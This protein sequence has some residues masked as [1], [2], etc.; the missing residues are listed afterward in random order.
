M[1]NIQKIKQYIKIVEPKKS[2]FIAHLIFFMAR[3]LLDLYLAVPSANAITNITIG[4]TKS[5]IKW[6]IVVCIV[7]C[8]QQILSYI[9]D[10]LYYKT[11][12]TCWQNIYAKMYDKISMA[13]NDSFLTTSKQKIINTAYN[14][15]SVLGEFPHH[16][17]KYISFFIQAIVT[18]FI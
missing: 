18:I 2:L 11:I 17:T 6:L 13:T 8:I 12:E 16:A 1:N 3:Y 10:R 14:N 4:D 9:I 15:L 5:A 7:V